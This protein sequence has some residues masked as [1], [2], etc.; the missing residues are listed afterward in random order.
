MEKE[1]DKPDN[2]VDIREMTEAQN[3]LRALLAD[4]MSFVGM[5]ASKGSAMPST[6]E[7]YIM[8]RLAKVERRLNDMDRPLVV[9]P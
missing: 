8:S 4:Y 2:V 1:N 3:D 9:V 5:Q 7:I 6:T